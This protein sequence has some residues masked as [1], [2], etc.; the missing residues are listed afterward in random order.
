MG[1]C[2][3]AGRGE[4]EAAHRSPFQSWVQHPSSAV[5]RGN[6]LIAPF[7]KTRRERERGRLIKPLPSSRQVGKSSCTEAGVEGGYESNSGSGFL[8]WLCPF[9]AVWP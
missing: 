3:D 2:L 6:G 7:L 4:A 5:P 8:S 9:H 1:L